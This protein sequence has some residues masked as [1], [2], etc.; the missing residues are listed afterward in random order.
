[1]KTA[2]K[3]ITDLSPKLAEFKKNPPPNFC[4]F[5]TTMIFVLEYN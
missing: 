5:K 4:P 2:L 3:E 1:M